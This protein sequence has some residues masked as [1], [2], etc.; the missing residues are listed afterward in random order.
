MSV[1]GQRVAYCDA[2]VCAKSGEYR[3]WLTAL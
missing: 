1:S 3:K 2:A